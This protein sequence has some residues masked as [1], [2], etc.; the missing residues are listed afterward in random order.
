MFAYVRGKLEEIEDDI[1]V[2]ET[3]GIGYEIYCA[4]PYQFQESLGQEVKVYTYQ[5]VREDLH[6]LYGFKREEEKSLFKKLIQVSGIGPKSA[7]AIIGQVPV[8]DFAQAIEQEDEKFLTK[9][10]GVG[11]KTARQ[12]ILDLKGKVTEWL[13]F[14]D[15]ESKTTETIHMIHATS[16]YVDEAIEALR[17]LGYSNREIKSIEGKLKAENLESTDDV[18]KKGCNY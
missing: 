5:Y 9:F 14:H 15:E 16:P 18:V 7:S 3:A 1:L 2:V 10:P 12:M 4:N 17:A 8:R 6:M 13:T 11:K